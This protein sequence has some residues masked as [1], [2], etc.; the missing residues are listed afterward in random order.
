[1][2]PIVWDD[3][4][5]RPKIEH[6]RTTSN[7]ADRALHKWSLF[8][9]LD[10]QRDYIIQKFGQR[11]VANDGTGVNLMPVGT[12][13][14]EAIVTLDDF[15]DC[16]FEATLEMER[17]GYYYGAEANRKGITAEQ[18]GSDS[19][20]INMV[21]TATALPDVDQISVVANRGSVAA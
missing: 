14:S 13:F 18:S 9:Q 1:M 10:A 16:L 7:S 17:F 21:Y 3:N 19:G 15:K 6:A 5:G 2:A 12:P 8:L 20:R 4:L 11:F